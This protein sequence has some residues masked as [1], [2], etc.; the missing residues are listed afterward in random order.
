MLSEEQVLEQINE[1]QETII[2]VDT[3]IEN[4][5][6][7]HIFYDTCSDKYTLS[8]VPINGAVLN[9]YESLEETFDIGNIT[10]SFDGSGNTIYEVSGVNEEDNFKHKYRHWTNPGI[11]NTLK[12]FHEANW[13][14]P[15]IERMFRTQHFK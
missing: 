11:Y 8:Y 1:N 12:L 10:V 6:N 7:L 15:T 5:Y 3:S 9:L 2:V 4:T 13:T 14:H